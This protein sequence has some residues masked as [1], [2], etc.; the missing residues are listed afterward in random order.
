MQKDQHNSELLINRLL[1]AELSADAKHELNR[2]LIREPEMMRLRDDYQKI[3]ALASAA[4]GSIRSGAEIDLAAVFDAAPARTRSRRMGVHRGWLMIP[5]AIAAAL[6]AMVI[7]DPDVHH[8]S[9]APLVSD[10]RE[11]FSVTPESAWD[12]SK[13]TMPVS[14][15]PKIRSQTGRDVIGVVGDD[16]NLYWIEVEKKRTVRWPAGS[17][18]TPDASDSM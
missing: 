16:G 7:P 2:T 18:L 4:L 10:G 12:G 6:L 13:L 1:D 17:S 9:T 5:G 8:P 14:T 3:D 11:L 15:A